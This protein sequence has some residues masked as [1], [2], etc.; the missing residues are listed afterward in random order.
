MQK[1]RVLTL[2]VSLYLPVNIFMFAFDLLQI[3]IGNYFFSQNVSS[4]YITIYRKLI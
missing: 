3:D 1:I 4:L 2:L